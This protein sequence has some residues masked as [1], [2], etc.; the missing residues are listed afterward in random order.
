MPADGAALGPRATYRIQLTPD[1]GF[2]HIADLADY[3][4]FL[5]VSHVYCSPYLQ[6]APGSMHGYDVTDPSRLSEELG[7]DEGFARM[8]AALRDHGLGHIADHVPNHVAADAR[9]PAWWDVLKHGR[10]SRYASWFDI[11]WGARDGKVMLGILEDDL[12][13]ILE[14]GELSRDGSLLRYFEHALPIAPGTEE[15]VDLHPL[16]DAQHYELVHWSY[17]VRNLNYRRFFDVQKLVGL[18]IEEPEVFEAVHSKILELIEA[19]LLQGLRIDHIDGLRD[20]L[21]YLQRM[22]ERIGDSFLVV[23]KILDT[24]ETLPPEWPVDGTTGY[25]FIGLVGGLFIDRSSEKRLTRFYR[26]FTGIDLD[27]DELARS[28][29]MLVMRFVLPAEIS[30][31]ARKLA[32]VF[33]SLSWSEEIDILRVA[34]AETI[35]GLGVYRTYITPEGRVSAVDRMRIEDAVARARVGSFLPSTIFDRLSSVLLLE[36]GG[37][38]GLDFVLS[39]QQ[40][41][42]SVMAKA[43]ED[44]FFYNYNRFIAL[45][46]VGSSPLRFGRDPS[47]LFAWKGRGLLAS[48]THD[49]KRSEDVRARLACLSEIPA[50]WEICV[51]ELSRLAERYRTADMP[52]RNTEYFLLQTL[53]GAWP[54]DVERASRYMTKAAREAKRYTSW[55]DP[56]R[57]YEESLERYV[58]GI[59]GDPAFVETLEGFVGRILEAGRV[60]SLAQ[61][62]IKLTMP[63]VP[64]IYQGCELWDLSL[65]DP[66]NRRPVDHDARL[67]ARSRIE[68]VDARSLWAE[69]NDGAPKLL[70]ILR[71]LAL[72]AD[73]P[74]AFDETPRP[75]TVSGDRATNAI[76][77]A[78]GEKAVVLVPRLTLDLRWGATQIELPEGVWRNEFTGRT[79]EGGGTPVEDVLDGFPVSLLGAV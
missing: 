5:G 16:L 73:A 61:T 21:A 63:G 17:A 1:A 74:G 35:A 50:E 4:A 39:L 78:R 12:Q 24:D 79:F 72:R 23:E 62:L 52:D 33:D 3:L 34:L 53:V 55:L 20:P 65:V 2:D 22:R 54:L 8:C 46:E 42:G 41:T 13:E 58:R 48:S 57:G 59:L 19:G 26:E 47:E 14:R 37:N 38:E 71:A 27:P 15:I 75:L 18:R 76:A 29:K 77:Y 28:R 7:G 49:T 6:A 60:N 30:L 43:I 25:E 45:N 66:D 36:Q 69:P 56:D 68:N 67:R 64:D 44:T 11:D 51:K 32:R 31:L 70:L 10:A 40:L 9:Q